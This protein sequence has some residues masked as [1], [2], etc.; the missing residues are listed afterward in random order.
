MGAGLTCHCI[1]N[2]FG[3][4]AANVARMKCMD[5]MQCNSGRFRLCTRLTGFRF[6]TTS[7]KEQGASGEDGTAPRMPLRRYLCRPEPAIHKE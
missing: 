5:E 6:T 3:L 1:L 7:Y 2:L 4:I